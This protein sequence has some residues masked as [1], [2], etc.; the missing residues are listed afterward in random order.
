[1]KPGITE[2]VVPKRTRTGILLQMPAVQAEVLRRLA[3]KT[4]LSQQ[5][6]RE[7]LEKSPVFADA[8]TRQL[9]KQFSAWQEKQAKEDIF[10]GL[11][12]ENGDA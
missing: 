1:M 3:Q 9:R 12:E 6:L 4:G 7:E 8:I 2:D 11:R 5:S 10:A